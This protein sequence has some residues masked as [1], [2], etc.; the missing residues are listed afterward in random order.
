MFLIQGPAVHILIYFY[1]FS[2]VHR[3]SNSVSLPRY[4]NNYSLYDLVYYGHYSH[5][6]GVMVTAPIYQVNFSSYTCTYIFISLTCHTLYF[7]ATNCW[8]FVSIKVCTNYF[9][10]LAR[11]GGYQGEKM[12][13]CIYNR[14]TGPYTKWHRLLCK[15]LDTSTVRMHEWLSVSD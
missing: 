10:G 8:Q 14:I 4:Y 9:H 12:E 3:V 5:I 7:S 6:S 2:S 1:L 13:E 15:R 11:K